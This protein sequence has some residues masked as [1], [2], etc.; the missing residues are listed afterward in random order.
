[1]FCPKCKREYEEGIKV[2]SDCGVELVEE[3]PGEDDEKFEFIEFEPVFS[4]NN[5]G[6]IALIKSL[7]KSENIRYYIN[8]EQISLIHGGIFMDVY[9]DKN[10]KEEARELLESFIKG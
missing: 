6:D 10:K 5:I 9:V 3:L 1:M 8:G 4:T 7:L 2:C